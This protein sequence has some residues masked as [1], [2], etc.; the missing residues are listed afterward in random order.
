MGESERA[1]AVED[2]ANAVD[3]RGWTEC[4]IADH[5][6]AVTRVHDLRPGCADQHSVARMAAAAANDNDSF[7]E[8]AKRDAITMQGILRC[9]LDPTTGL[10]VE[11]AC[12]GRYSPWG[13]ECLWERRQTRPAAFWTLGA[14][15]AA[16]APDRFV[17]AVSEYW[18]E[19]RPYSSWDKPPYLGFAKE[20]PASN[21]G[22]P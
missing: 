9:A 18:D 13:H 2:P 12:P 17:A 3:M 5:I 14:Q 22:G 15:V 20:R 19:C 21:P 6:L 8:A 11:P 10:L 16:L 1:P 4:I 7:V